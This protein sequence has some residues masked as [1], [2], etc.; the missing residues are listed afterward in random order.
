VGFEELAGDHGAAADQL[1]YTHYPQTFG[2]QT[3]S[4]KGDLR[5]TYNG[6][7]IRQRMKMTRMMMASR[8]NLL[9]FSCRRVIASIFGSLALMSGLIFCGVRRL[10]ISSKF[11]ARSLSRPCSSSC[12]SLGRLG[13]LRLRRCL[14]DFTP[15]GPDRLPSGFP[16]PCQGRAQRSAKLTALPRARLAALPSSPP[17]PPSAKENDRSTHNLSEY[18]A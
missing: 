8:P 17:G 14:Q 18:S 12:R 6:P 2:Q 10:L 16:P 3:R 9:S 11:S 13:F 1:Q 4:I 15:Q 5:A 7:E